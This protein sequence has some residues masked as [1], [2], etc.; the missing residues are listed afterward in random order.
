M[1]TAV[2]ISTPCPLTLMSSTRVF[3][4]PRAF[5]PS[6]KAAAAGMTACTPTYNPPATYYAATPSSVS[7]PNTSVLAMTCRSSDSI[8]SSGSVGARPR[9][10]CLKGIQRPSLSVL[11]DCMLPPLPHPSP[12]L[13]SLSS[14]ATASCRK[15]PQQ[16]HIQ[17]RIPQQRHSGL[18]LAAL[19]VSQFAVT[20]SPPLRISMHNVQSSERDRDGGDRD[21]EPNSRRAARPCARNRPRLYSLRSADR[22]SQVALLLSDQDDL[23]PPPICV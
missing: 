14:A 17:Q 6:T 5:D 10:D 23:S 1:L 4:R 13:S 2:S 11:M 15:P 22:P 9:M 16:S 20:D 12:P 19:T 18:P 7:H 3:K 21:R 8:R